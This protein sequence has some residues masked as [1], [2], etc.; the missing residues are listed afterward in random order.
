[1]NIQEILKGKPLHVIDDSFINEE[2][3]RVGTVNIADGDSIGGNKWIAQV[4]PYGHDHGGDFPTHAEALAY[5][6]LF[7][8]AIDLLDAAQYAVECIELLGNVGGNGDQALQA[9]KKAINKA[10]K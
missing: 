5:G 7:G 2:N 3:K 6:K 8:A 10:T 9:L 4:N 1:M